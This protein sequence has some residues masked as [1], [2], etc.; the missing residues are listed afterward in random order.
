MGLENPQECENSE[1]QSSKSYIYTS[2]KIKDE[3]YKY[4]QNPK[5]PRNCKYCGV[6][7]YQRGVVFPMTKRVITWLDYERCTCDKAKKYWEKHDR[8]QEKIKAQKEQE[9][10]NQKKIK[11]IE[12]LLGS[13]KI[14]KRFKNRTFDSFKIDKTNKKAYENSKLYADS[15]GKFKEKGEGIY[16]SGSFGTGKTHLAVAIALELINKGIPVICMTAIDLL[17]EIK[18]TFDDYNMSEYQI[19]KA[20]KQADLLVI[21]DLGKEYCSNWAITMLYDI[22]NDRYERCLPTIVTTNYNDDDLV[23]RLAEKSNY[24]SAGAIVSRLHEMTMEISMSGPDKRKKY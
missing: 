4:S 5:S 2:K 10:E 6:K 16:Y 14:K 18:R 8:K 9:E 22:I 7:L 13:S 1:S 11:Y 21:D 15:F 24:E 12:K 17:A 20:Y 19:L 23:Q 3:G